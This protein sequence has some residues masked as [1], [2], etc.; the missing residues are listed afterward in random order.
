MKSIKPLTFDYSTESQG[1]KTF[2]IIPE[3]IRWEESA[4][5]PEGKWVL[6]GTD[7]K[8][9]TKEAF[10]MENIQRFVD[11]SI[12]RIYCVTVYVMNED[13]RFL[14]LLHK[15]LGKWVPPGGKID[16]HETPE[17]SAKR[18]CF[19]ETGI[20]ISLVGPKPYVNGRTLPSFGMELNTL[21]PG[22]REHIDLIYLGHPIEK[23]ELK[24]SKREAD[25][26][27]WFTLEEIEKMNTFPS[28]IEWSRFFTE[29]KN[30]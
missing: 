4:D 6:T 22:I 10:T 17:E 3:S 9:N 25:G 14:L 24:I 30:S 8:K 28:V 7:Q 11:E 27:G 29:W 16:R 26:I 5:S 15:K 20:A 13:K 19:E 12:Q 21:V 1:T 18:E 2:S 23:Q